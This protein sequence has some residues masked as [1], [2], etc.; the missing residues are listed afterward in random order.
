MKISGIYKIVNK[1]NGKY[2]VGSSLC[3]LKEGY[4]PG[5]FRQ[6]EAF[7]IKGTHRNQKLQIAWNEYG[8]QHFEF[9]I[10]ETLIGITPEKLLLAEQKYLDIAFQEQERCYNKAF[11]AGGGKVYDIHP[12]LGKKQSDES[13]KK[14]SES[15]KIAQKGEKNARYDKTFYTFLN[16]QTNET[17]YG[18]QY[19]FYTKYGLSSANISHLIRNRNKR[20]RVKGWILKENE[21]RSK[22]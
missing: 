7:L 14:N 12:L 15:N 17:F 4:L 9:V 8:P 21:K 1:V 11:I 22:G 18:T 3:I 2:Q 10:I 5:R 20:L 19:H 13:R 6:H 16:L